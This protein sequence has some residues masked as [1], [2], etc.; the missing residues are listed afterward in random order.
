MNV[1]VVVVVVVVI[2]LIMIICCF[3][4]LAGSCCARMNYLALY[5]CFS[6]IQNFEHSL[7]RNASTTMFQRELAVCVQLSLFLPVH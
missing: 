7:L 5:V 2:I 4:V 3:V 6:L 1:I